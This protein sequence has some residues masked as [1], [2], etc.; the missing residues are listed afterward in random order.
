MRLFF[1]AQ[2]TALFLA[3]PFAISWVS[4]ATFK[5]ATG[6]FWV[7]IVAM[8]VQFIL[9]TASLYESTKKWDW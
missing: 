3:T 8:V 7:F 1:S 5:Y 4:T 2:L 6:L 9:M